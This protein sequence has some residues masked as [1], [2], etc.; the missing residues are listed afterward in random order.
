MQFITIDSSGKAVAVPAYNPKPPVQKTVPVGGGG[1]G[2]GGGGRRRHWWWAKVPLG[3][4]FG[5][6]ILMAGLRAQKMTWW[7]LKLSLVKRKT[8]M[9]KDASTHT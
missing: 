4:D 5:D 3:E 9:R 6:H 2:G 1:G 7:R 8:T